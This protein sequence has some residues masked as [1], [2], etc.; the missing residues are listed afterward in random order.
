MKASLKLEYS[1]RVLSQLAR[2]NKGG[3]VTRVEEL[4][5][6]EAIPRN[7]LVQLLNELREGGLVD[8]KR[9]KTGGY[10][11]AK[12]PEDITLKQV[13]A[14]VEPDLIDTKI[15][16]KGASGPQVAALWR[17]VSKRFDKSLTGFTVAQLALTESGTDFEI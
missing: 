5:K 2:K 12:A 10:R 15:T 1:L 8:S 16:L 11:L 9:G 3:A 14:V 7:Y 4:A 6:I 17:E 13:L